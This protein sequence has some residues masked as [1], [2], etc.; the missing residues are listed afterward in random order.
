[1]STSIERVSHD[2]ASILQCEPLKQAFSIASGA[3]LILL[4]LKKRSALRWTAA[5]GG[6]MIYY[7]VNKRL[8][9]NYP[10]G[11]THSLATKQTFRESIT[12]DKSAAELFSLWLNHDVVSKVMYPYG[13]MT[14]LGPDHVRSTI[15]LPVG[16]LELEAL[17]VEARP[18]ELVHWRTV[19]DSMLQVD[20]R[21]Q[22]SPAPEGTGTVATLNYEV[23][24]SKV[25]AG[26]V[27]RAISGFFKRAPQ[28]M[29]R[30]VMEN[31][32]SIAE[33]GEISR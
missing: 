16:K 6:A 10:A 7:A 25:P 12:I 20:E 18:N 23:D 1:M 33:T 5:A 32:K 26:E 13:Y 28:S 14:S 29:L 11:S 31:F 3:V 24:F 9:T 2:P 22:F 30:R 8:A 4:V 27:L 19:S 21:M 17:L 15:E